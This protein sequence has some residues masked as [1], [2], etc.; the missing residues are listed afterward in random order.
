MYRDYDQS[1]PLEGLSSLSQLEVDNAKQWVESWQRQVEHFQQKEDNC[2]RQAKQAEKDS[3]RQAMEDYAYRHHS[4]AEEKH[5]YLE[6]ARKQVKPAE[7]RLQ[8]VEQ[9]ISALFAECTV[10]LTEVSTSDHLEAQ[11]I[12]S[13]RL[14]R[15]GQLKGLRSD[16]S[17]R[18]TLRGNQKPDRKKSLLQQ[19][20][21]LLQF[22]HQK[23][24]KTLKGKHPGPD[25][26]QESPQ[27]VTMVKT[28]ALT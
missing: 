23:C 27:S 8:W 5:S 20:L 3:T 13:K 15:S 25:D 1:R 14:S 6:E 12:T 21:R 28:K 18:I 16:R 19:I 10:S 22:I 26:S 2:A 9:Q 17:G 24:Q 11:A 7:M 4:E